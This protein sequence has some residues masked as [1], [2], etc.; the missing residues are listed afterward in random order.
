MKKKLIFIFIALLLKS[1][2]FS[3]VSISPDDEFYID[4]TGWLLKGIIYYVP[5]TK[6]YPVNTVK[7]ILNKVLDSD[8]ES[9]VKKAEYYCSKYFGKNWKFSLKADFQ[10][11][12]RSIQDAETVNNEKYDLN[13]YA[14]GDFDFGKY[15]GFSYKT[16]LNFFNTNDDKNLLMP[17]GRFDSSKVIIDGF[18]LYNENLALTFDLNASVSFG[19][20]RNYI[21]LGVN[22]NSYG[23]FSDSSVTLN[24]QAYQSLNVLYNYTGKYFDFV[25]ILSA[26]AA[27][28]PFEKNEYS[29]GKY[30]AF[31]SIRFPLFSF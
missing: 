10:E 2:S 1:F 26:L 6:P 28:N 14:T 3:Q 12:L 7:S 8:S 16:G 17:Y 31:H 25:Q 20:E 24:E 13:F 15:I 18:S 5:Q 27:K 22:K 21:S 30:Y 4:V 9:D 23:P 29:L 19:T 11:V